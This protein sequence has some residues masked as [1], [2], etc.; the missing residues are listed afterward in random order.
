[1]LR[2]CHLALRLVLP[3]RARTLQARAREHSCRHRAVAAPKAAG[4]APLHRKDGSRQSAFSVIRTC[5]CRAIEIQLLHCC[6]KATVVNSAGRAEQAFFF[7]MLQQGTTFIGPRRAA[8]AC[9][10]AHT[11]EHICATS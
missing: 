5:T 7:H 8:H 9:T 10:C 2:G 4:A 1:M 6:Y 3:L 11:S